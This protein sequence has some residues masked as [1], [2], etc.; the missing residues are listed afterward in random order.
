[1]LFKH[2]FVKKKNRKASAPFVLKKKK[3][4]LST[5]KMQI[6]WR[7]HKKKKKAKCSFLF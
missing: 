6:D 7:K 1:M 4:T 5:T 2:S 3:S